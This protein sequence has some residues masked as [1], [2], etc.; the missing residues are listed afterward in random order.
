MEILAVQFTQTI[1]NDAGI[2]RGDLQ[3]N[4]YLRSG[5]KEVVTHISPKVASEER[6]AIYFAELLSLT[7]F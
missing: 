7:F 3:L 1:H 4:T 6:K 5:K 2:I